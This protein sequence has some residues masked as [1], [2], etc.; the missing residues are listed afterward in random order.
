MNAPH[1]RIQPLVDVDV[2]VNDVRMRTAALMNEWVLPNEE[3]L[4]STLRSDGDRDDRGKLESK[5]RAAVKAAGLWAP[6]I[7]AEFGGMGAGFLALA[8]MNEL[9]GYS[10]PAGALFGIV[11]PNAG[12]Q[13]LLVAH[14]T[15]EQQRRWLAPLVSGELESGF[16][17]TEPERAGSD[18]RSLMTTAVVDGSEWCINGHKWFTSNGADANFL[19]VSCRVDGPDSQRVV[20]IL[21]PTDTPGVELVRRIPIWGQGPSDHCEFLYHDVRVPLE[22]VIGGAQAR[23]G[24]QQAQTRLGV[25]R[26]FHCM[27]AV[28]QMQRAFNLMLDR[29]SVRDVRDGRL[30]D[31]QFVQG[32]IADSYADI[33]TARLMTIHAAEEIERNSPRARVEISTIKVVVPQTWHRVVDRAIQVWGAAGI[34][35]D[36]PLAQMY[37]GARM[38]R[39]ADGP[40]EVHRIAVAKA[41]LREHAGGLLAFG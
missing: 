40:D 16:S 23:D 24:E 41:L 17:M 21:V 6:H 4:T 32:F 38:L 28:G 3:L 5:I 35:D 36:L 37:L 12:N 19:V 25:G 34:T 18:P 10:V 33:Q 29:A 2:E 8:Y 27:Y 31:K 30:C 26:I 13:H 11:A 7:P 39:I 9:L 1:L 14:G 20:Q 15:E 22:N